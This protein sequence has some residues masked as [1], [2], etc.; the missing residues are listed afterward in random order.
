M[1]TIELR[2]GYRTSDPRLDRIPQYDP[3]SLRYPI[4][5]AFAP[6]ETQKPLRSYTW[7][8]GAETL[9]AP[10]LYLDQRREGAC[11]GFAFAHEAAAKPEVAKGITD[12]WARE[13]YWAAQKLDP[14][15][16][17]AWPGAF[18]FYEGTSTLAAASALK[19]AGVIKN[20]LWGRT[21]L[22]VCY[23]LAYKGPVVLGIDWYESMFNPDADG[24][25]APTGSIAGG[26]AILAIGVSLKRNAVLLHNS[27]GPDWGG[28]GRM[29]GRA[30]LKRDHLAVLLAAGGDACLP[31]R[32]H[33]PLY[34]GRANSVL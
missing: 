12:Q 3:K 8:V 2:A 7:P 30:W 11:E 24:F 14:W 5:Q 31:I 15:D 16:G 28:Q 20:Y 26:H 25:I 29:A 34:P 33:Q 17:G 13:L 21:E 19:A 4:R 9:A 18:P 27:W 10:Q 23:A 22:E 32:L 6:G 1:P